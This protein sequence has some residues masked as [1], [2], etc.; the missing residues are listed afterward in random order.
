MAQAA[1][2]LGQKN[3]ILT[4]KELS[5]GGGHIWAQ[6]DLE[7]NQRGRKRTH[8]SAPTEAFWLIN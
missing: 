2:R 6:E 5:G 3:E 7:E 1:K 4:A 8:S